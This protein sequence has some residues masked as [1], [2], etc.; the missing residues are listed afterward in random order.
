MLGL[1]QWVT[2]SADS[3]AFENASALCREAVVPD[4]TGLVVRMASFNLAGHLRGSLTYACWTLPSISYAAG[5]L[6]LVQYT[7]RTA[8]F[9]LP[10]TRGSRHS[11][12]TPDPFS[13]SFGGE[14]VCYLVY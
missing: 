3:I 5:N 11:F 9:A 4:L 14:T 13:N 12:E 7:I 1:Q 8:S 10:V 6:W 2:G